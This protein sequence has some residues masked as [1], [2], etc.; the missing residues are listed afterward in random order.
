MVVFPVRKV[1]DMKLEE[2][3]HPPRLVY[4]VR[5][6]LVETEHGPVWRASIEDSLNA[7]RRCFANLNALFEFLSGRTA[8]YLTQN[9]IP[10]ST[11]AKDRD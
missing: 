7:E 5:C 11:K 6:W 1:H 10:E 8:D 3:A 9:A 2:P 4:L